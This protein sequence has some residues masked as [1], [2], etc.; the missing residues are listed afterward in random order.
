MRTRIIVIMTALVVILNI[1]S[2]AAE[3]T[4]VIIKV[5]GAEPNVEPEPN[6]GMC[7]WSAKCPCPY[8]MCRTPHGR[9]RCAEMGMP[10]TMMEQCHTMM[11]ISIQADDPEVILAMREKMMLTEDQINKLQTIVR[12]S[13]QE[14]A[15]VLT[16]DQRETAQKMFSQPTT[17]MKMHDEMMSKMQ[18]QPKK[19]RFERFKEK[20][21]VGGDS[22]MKQTTC[23]VTGKPINRAYWTIYKGKK[24]YFC[25][26]ICKP[27]FEKDPEKYVDKLP[28][29]KE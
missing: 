11:Q 22:L 9:A 23:P 8:M 16:A 19:G 5:W 7:Q 24:V 14:A 27:E 18:M 29:F 21:G 10:E 6:M 17:F 2:Y 12:K 13:W 25:C 26:P 4:N 3:E 20:L 15:D 1:P 28:Q